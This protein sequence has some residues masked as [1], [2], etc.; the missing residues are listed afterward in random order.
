MKTKGIVKG[1]HYVRHDVGIAFAEIQQFH[2]IRHKTVD[3]LSG[4]VTGKKQC[5]P[6]RQA[7]TND[8]VTHTHFI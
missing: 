8:Q 6:K 3:F 5:K 2:I 7:T 1:T 4:K